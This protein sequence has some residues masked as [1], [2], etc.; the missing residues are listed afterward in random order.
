MTTASDILQHLIDET[1]AARAHFQVWWALRNLAL[2]D[3]YDVMNDPEYVQFFHASNSGHYKLIFVAIGKIY[4]GDT[5]SAGIRSLKEA[6]RAE[7]HGNIA[8]EL[9]ADLSIATPQVRRLLTIRNRTVLHNEQSIS[10]QQV[11]QLDGGITANEIHELIDT[12]T[13]AI[14]NV[15]RA[16]GYTLRASVCNSYQDAT[17]AMLGR[18]RKGDT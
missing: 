2:P 3:F 11:Y 4:D 16:L 13:H 5:R 8:D 17:M 1:N 6:L 15:A 10:R 12:T 18:L 7:E 14:N 9:E